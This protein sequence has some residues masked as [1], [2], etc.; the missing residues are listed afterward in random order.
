MGKRPEQAKQKIQM[1]SNDVKSYS[2]SLIIK[3][4]SSKILLIDVKTGKD[5]K[6]KKKKTGKF[7]MLA[8]A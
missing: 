4:K 3:S 7:P 1:V 2:I 5:L 6:K 8:T